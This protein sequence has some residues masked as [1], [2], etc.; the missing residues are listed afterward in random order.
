MNRTEFLDRLTAL[1]SDI[2]ENERQEALQYYNDYLDDAGA[3]KEQDVL[4]ALGSPETLAASIREGLMEDG[5]EKGE[6]SERGFQTGEKREKFGEVTDRRQTGGTDQSHA[7]GHKNKESKKNTG[8][9]LLLIICALFAA[10]VLLP[11]A[12]AALITAAALA[13]A[14][15]VVTLVLLITGIICIIAGVISL[16]VALV[17]ILIAP[18]AAMV[19]IGIG[20]VS[21]GAGILLVLVMGWILVKAFPGCFRSCAGLCRRLLVG[22]G[23]RQI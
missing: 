13:V 2:P 4:D 10:P 18:A 8:M 3:E 5:L 21:I 16:I 20:L 9:L 7:A 17:K 1:L 12:F 22:K 23:G 11:L 6:F 14:V 15:V 19:A